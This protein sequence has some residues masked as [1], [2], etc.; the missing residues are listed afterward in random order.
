MEKQKVLY[1]YIYE[2]KNNGKV[3]KVGFS[4]SQSKISASKEFSKLKN[5]TV[6]VVKIFFVDEMFQTDKRYQK[7]LG[8][9][10]VNKYLRENGICLSI[11]KG[12]SKTVPLRVI[13]ENEGDIEGEVV[14]KGLQIRT[15]EPEEI[16]YYSES[17]CSSECDSVT[18]DAIYSESEES[19]EDE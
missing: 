4:Y 7:R 17:E 14:T 19:E 15:V 8:E 2:V 11:R 12:N 18:S 1:G 3:L 10:E 6:D 9:V 5:K 13:L 16:S